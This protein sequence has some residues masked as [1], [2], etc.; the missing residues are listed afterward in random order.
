MQ[1]G[2]GEIHAAVARGFGANQAAAVCQAFA[3]EHGGEFV[4]HAFV[5]PEQEADFAPAH[6]DVACGHVQICADVAGKLGHKG[7]AK[8]HHF[9]IGFAFG[10]KVGAA[11][12]AA[13]G[14]GGERVF[15]HLL[16][17]EEFQHAQ[18]HGGVKA[19]AAF[20][21]TD[22]GVHLHAVAAV[23]LHIALVVH[24]RHAEHHHALGLDDAFQQALLR[25]FG[26]FFQ[27]RFQAAKHF[28]NGLVEHGLIG[29]ALFNCLK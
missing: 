18:I 19:Q 1:H 2:L 4:A 7:L 15:E 3:G 20:V 26:V 21:G 22:G 11:F 5:L 9:G 17:G 6:A 16:K 14:Q 24:P 27:K 12:A 25:V 10:V 29:V 8:A 23:Y 28:F 13:H